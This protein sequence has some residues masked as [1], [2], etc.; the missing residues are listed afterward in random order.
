MVFLYRWGLGYFHT[1]VD[2]EPLTEEEKGIIQKVVNIMLNTPLIP[3]TSCRYCVDGCPAK[4]KIPDVFNALNTL[5]K[6]PSDNRPKF[7]YNGLV[8]NSG[9]ASDC[10][11]CGQC[12]GVCPQHMPI[13]K[14]LEEA[15]E[16]L[17]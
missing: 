8:A 7:F 17:D 3:C 1:F 4:I 12:E 2:F 11:K 14:Y 13:I 15:A 16:K 9:R 5:R 6:F 10:L